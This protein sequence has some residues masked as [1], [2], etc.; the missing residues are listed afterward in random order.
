M[1]GGFACTRS[2]RCF[3]AAAEAAPV[4]RL[5]HHAFERAD[6]RVHDMRLAGADRRAAVCASSRAASTIR[7]RNATTAT[8]L[9]PTRSCVRSL[10]GPMPSH[11]AMSWFGMP[12][13]PVK[14]PCCHRGAVLPVEV[15]ARADAVEVRV[16]V[17]APLQH[18]ELAPGVGVDAGLV[19]AVPGD[20]VEHRACC[21]LPASAASRHCAR[22]WAGSAR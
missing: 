1:P 13:M 3:A 9:A 10:I 19:G 7:R 21:R 14:L 18:V 5:R 4:R 8:S 17:D 20:E 22:C 12:A 2:M 15:V 16:D 6:G 11:I